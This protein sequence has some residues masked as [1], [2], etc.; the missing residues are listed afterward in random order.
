M[1]LKYCNICVSPSTRPGLNLNSDGICTACETASKKKQ[2]DWVLRRKHLESIFDR[3][4]RVRDYDYDCIVPVSGGKDSIY[5]VHMVKNVFNMNPLCITWRTLARTQRGEENLT[6]LKKIG[7]DHIDFSPNPDGI[8]KITVKAFED[9]GDSSLIDHLAIYNV[10]PNFALRFNLPLVIWG[11]NPYMEYGGDETN[12]NLD[13]QSSKF[14]REHHIFKGKEAVN[15]ISDYIARREINS[16][17]PPDDTALEKIG[18]EPIYLGF[19]IPWDAKKNKE[20]AIKYGF[21]PRENGPIMGLYD[22][23]DLDCMNIVIHHYFKW[24]KFGFNR[25]TDNA[26]NEIRKGR[27]N[28]TEAI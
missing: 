12:S 11:E 22:Y 4:R 19:Y 5:Q 15:W 3:H 13:Q 10:I 21:K 6:A 14:V 7:V 2:I 25:I 27:L 23:A 18:Y 16:Y 28:R 20:I 1:N 17:I 26:S 8:N 9:Y 24:L